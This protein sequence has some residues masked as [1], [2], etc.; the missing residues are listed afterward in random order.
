[1]TQLV[2]VMGLSLLLL[3]CHEPLDT[4]RTV[5]P[6]TS[7]GA[8]M[9]REG[10][11]RV[12]Y[13]GQLAQKAAGE[14]TTVDVSG[15]LGRAVC[16]EGMQSPSDAPLKLAAIVQ[17]RA[18]IIKLV[19]TILPKP[20]LEDLQNFLVALLPLAD[21]GTMEHAIA[22]LGDLLGTMH[23][24]P[25]FP[26]ALERCA[27]RNG[28]RP[29]K[30]AAG[31]M[32]TIVEYPDIDMFLGKLLALIA[33]GGT[34]EGEWKQVLTAL[35]EEMRTAQPVA[36]PAAPDRTLRLALNL[37]LSTHPDLASGKARPLVARDH[38][39]LAQVNFSAGQIMAPFV[40]KN[41]DGLADADA[42][43]RFIDTNG[44]PV[45]AP[46]PFAE[47]GVADTAARDAQGRALSAPGATTT[48]YKYLDLDGT[49]MGGMTRETLTL[50]DPKKDTAL[51]LVHGASALLG[52]RMTKTKMYMDPAG[53]L[54]STLTYQG[55][56]VSQAAVLDLLH[57]FVQILGDPNADQT[58]QATK[59]LLTKH[60][61]ELTRVIGAMFDVSD[62]GKK[63]NEAVIPESSTLYD[64]LA[65]L[66]ARV[67]RVPGLADD[68]ILALQDPH[69][70]GF[71]PMVARMMVQRNQVDFNHT[72]GPG[73][74]A[75]PAQLDTVDPVDRTKP[76]SDYNRSVMQR[77]AHL[78]H[79]SNGT[80]F[81]NK[82]NA[83]VALGPVPIVT[84]IPKCGLF[85]IDDLALFFALSMA[86]PAVIQATKGTA[87]EATTYAEA[88]FREHLTN[89]TVKGLIF[90]NGVGDGLLET[91]TGITGFTR[92]PT[93]AAAARSL[94][95]KPNEQSAFLQDTTEPV[96]CRDGDKFTDVHDK[97][98]VAWETRMV[99][100]PSGFANDTFYDAVR[101][102]ITAFAKH[103]E[104]VTFNDA[105][106]T[107]TK[108]QNAVKIFV[109]I[110]AMMHE[111]W[112]SPNGSYFGK[113]YQSADRKQPRFAYTDNL[114]SFE[115]LIAESIS[116][117][118]L[119]PAIIDL[120]PVLYTFTIDGTP[121]GQPARPVLTGAA[122]YLFDPKA[123][124]AGVTYRNGQTTTVM[125]DGKT[126]VAR[127]TPYYL[128]ADAYAHRRNALAQA[129]MAQQTA[130]KTATTAL[131]DQMLTVEK[132][133]T[134]YRFK[135][136]RMNAVTLNLVDFVRG[137]IKAHT[138]SG[139][140]DTW[141]HQ[142]LTSDLTDVLGGPVFA[143]LGDFVGKVEADPQA[144]DELY[145]LLQYLVNEADND[146]V[147]ATALTTLADQV[148]TFLDDP[149]LVPIARVMGAA[150][151]PKKGA[152]DAQLTLVKKARDV[153]TK[154]ALLTILRNLYR[155]DA[156]GVY[157]ASDLAD[158]V[159]EL[160]RK[161]PGAGGRLNAL[162]YKTL[163]GET[164]D[165]FIDDQRG[166]TRFLNIV[167]ARGPHN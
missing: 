19:D 156:N 43:G 104:C 16:V 115:P 80:Q 99:N 149:N 15:S 138:T 106:Q 128:I 114:T 52:P 18:S 155:Q 62:R 9:Y 140:V 51:G 35:A 14:R 21:D 30:T 94:F 73:Y 137:R 8:I 78:I 83:R 86:D 133:G 126:P 40:D 157:P 166:F 75:N 76:D 151:D 113:K 101:P 17:Q 79:D 50:M 65:P 130:W 136:R 49:V 58:L 95:L 53:G 88:S 28:Y 67:L 59:T 87:R 141:I 3:G 77:I 131:I 105:T 92:F 153:D 145:R 135:N 24:N 60:E 84:D 81:C 33:P 10:C 134:R 55:Y 146:T 11:Q 160:N 68:L 150:M 148:Q 91:Q 70:K 122:R 22:S 71:A 89:S 123:T 118:D 161:T 159:S 107:C 109:D 142:Q 102:I 29:T 7:F 46:T 97:S 152:V 5:D 12:A 72:A 37:V 13:T 38:R 31:L 103:D 23:D 74:A 96:L 108:S 121:T 44:N 119:M 93:P 129:P 6:Y 63:H 167:K 100:N 25:D 125:S 36:N 127:A 41:A 64:D 32:H 143:A 39:G 164:R 66:I 132:V 90:D 34:A 158:V 117:A 56:D 2:S 139:D 4:N 124:P 1:M 85:Q 20:F 69:T 111:H 98:L 48:L 57:A 163:L 154:K 26:V 54:A 47:N 82:P 110:F 112:S 120:A 165:F 116:Q 144:R 147:F 42:Q 27:A 45:V 61:S 162:D